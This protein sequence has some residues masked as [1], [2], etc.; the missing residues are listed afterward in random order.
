VVDLSTNAKRKSKILSGASKLEI[1]LDSFTSAVSSQCGRFTEYQFSSSGRMIGV[2]VIVYGL[3]SRKLTNANLFSERTFNVFY[4]LLA[5]ASDDQKLELKIQDPSSFVYIKGVKTAISRSGTLRRLASIRESLG[6]RNS[7]SADDSLP[8][9]QD[10]LQFSELLANFKSLG[11]GARSQSHIFKVLAAILHLGNVTFQEDASANASSNVPCIVKNPQSLEIAADLLSVSY[12]NLKNSLVVQSTLVGREKCSI[13]LS[14]EDASNQRNAF[15]HILYSLLVSWIVEHLNKRLNKTENDIANLISIV[16]IP[17]IST[18]TDSHNGSFD[19]FLSN[20]AQ[21]RLFSHVMESVFG[22]NS[23]DALETS[24]IFDYN[25]NSLQMN[26]YKGLTTVLKSSYE[27]FAGEGLVAA[28]ISKSLENS[29]SLDKSFIS[30]TSLSAA[31]AGNVFA[32]VHFGKTVQYDLDTFVSQ[33]FDLASFASVFTS[34][35]ADNM[36]FIDELFT[37]KNGVFASQ[38]QA[39][40]SLRSLHRNQRLPTLSKTDAILPNTMFEVGEES[41]SALIDG[42]SQCR[43]WSVFCFNR[44]SSLSEFITK[45]SIKQMISS[46]QKCDVDWKH[47]MRYQDFATKYSGIVKVRGQNDNEVVKSF[48]NSQFWSNEK[49]V[50]GATCVFLSVDRWMWL[51]Q[52]IDIVSKQNDDAWGNPNRNS[53]DYNTE[54]SSQYDSEHGYQESFYGKEAPPRSPLVDI[55]QGKKKGDP[56]QPPNDVVES[57]SKI[58]ASRKSWVCCTWMITWWIPSF[59]LSIFGMKRPDIRMAWREKVALCIIIAFL[60]LL[61]L[62]LIIGLRFL[63]CPPINIKTQEEVRF[64]LANAKDN[65]KVPDRKPWVAAYGRYYDVSDLMSSHIKSY[66]ESE[67]NIGIPSYRIQELYGQDVSRLFYKADNWLYYCKNIPAPP[68]SWDN[69]DP[70]A[71]YATTNRQSSAIDPRAFHRNNAA[72]G[73]PQPYADNLNK[74][75]KGR[76]GYT[77]QAVKGMSSTSEAYMIIYDNVYYFTPMFSLGND[78]FSPLVRSLIQPSFAGQDISKKWLEES[79]RSAAN[80]RDLANALNC[81]NE[82]FYIG[83]VDRRDTLQCRFSNWMLL[84][85]SIVIVSV[86]G[87]KFLA[88]LQFGTRKNPELAE[89][90]VVCMVPCYTEGA[91]SL[92]RVFES[93]AT[94]EYD[95]KRKLLFVICDGM[96]MGAG[97]D[98]PTPRIV[99]DILGVDQSQDPEPQVF[100]SLGEGNRQLNMGKVYSGLYQVRGHS[101]PFVVVVKVGTPQERIKPGNRGKRDSQLLLMRFFNRVHFNA[102]FNPLE[103][104]LYHNL[105]NIIGVSPSFYEFIFFVDAD[106]EV[107]PTALNRMTSVMIN[108]SKIMGLCGETRIANERQS[109]ITFIQVYEYFISHHLS[110]AFESLFGTVTCLPGCFSMYRIRS[111]NKNIPLLVSPGVLGDYSLNT[112]D[113]LHMKNLLHLGEDRYLTT[114]MLKHFPNMRTKFTGEA[115]CSTSVPDKWSVLLSQ[116]RRWV[117][118]TVHNLLELCFLE[119]LCGFCCFSMRFIVMLDLFSTV[120]QPATVLYIAYLIYAVST[121]TEEF[122]LLS[123]ILIGAIYGLQ[124]FLFIIKREWQHIIWLLIYILAIPIFSFWI[125]VYSFWHFDDFSWGNTRI[126]VGEGKKTVYLTDGEPVIEFNSV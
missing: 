15:V 38:V 124:I 77:E 104:D 84:I 122:P 95:D 115:K 102:E 66:A 4:Q 41:V 23:T 22:G 44:S 68:V 54:S 61:L 47:G 109:W 108:D 26:M 43:L 18:P 20:Y 60:C 9:A 110:K 105:K 96:I 25:N 83:T 13:I 27:S 88:A 59:M 45:F 17:S 119:E 79:L 21:E 100:Q 62:F 75:A 98:R 40:D 120:V 46:K 78:I 34:K 114:L 64:V 5:G 67:G 6:S 86:I 10:A 1:V 65:V 81:M 118:S 16:D 11:I 55:E 56:K 30:G 103:L 117:N 36:G 63:I 121:T 116:R 31:K 90:F 97:N 52:A 37:A 3:Q 82:M 94:L 89:K 113:T 35:G 50:F 57:V 112:V 53:V 91:E 73:Y 76:I 33:E 72:D 123:I 12:V 85:A 2:K 126:V 93:L 39:K 28:S 14:P 70:N 29:L 125:P 24:H 92:T 71:K 42:I 19:L 69:L 51:N 99:L 49:V 58:S 107:E 74:Y 87:I 106:T 80:A 111:A 48:I 7:V 101:V 32:I 8:N